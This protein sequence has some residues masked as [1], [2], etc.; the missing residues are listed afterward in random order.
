MTGVNPNTKRQPK[1]GDIFYAELDGV[2]SEQRGY[3]P[4]LVLQNNKGNLHSP[5]LIVLPITSSIKR[6]DMPTHVLLRSAD[7]GLKKD[8][9]V[10]CENP[11]SISKARLGFYITSLSKSYMKEVAQAHLLAT[12][13][14]A[15]VDPAS[16]QQIW[17]EANRM[18]AA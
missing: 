1:I 7:T 10:L 18:N 13:V 17:R 4:C 14:I 15:F 12:S 8:S 3:R 6:L 11:V 16:L 5:N 2:G 9:I